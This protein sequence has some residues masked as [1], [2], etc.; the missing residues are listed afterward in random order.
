[1]ATLWRLIPKP[2]AFRATAEGEPKKKDASRRAEMCDHGQTLADH[3]E[4]GE[5]ASERHPNGGQTARPDP[6]VRGRKPYMNIRI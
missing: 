1:M 4:C 2:A 5:R 6:S 3:I